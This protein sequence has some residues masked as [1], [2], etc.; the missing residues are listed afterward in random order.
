MWTISSLMINTK[1]ALIDRRKCIEQE[2]EKAENQSGES[3][4]NNNLWRNISQTSLQ[5]AEL[6]SVCL[7]C[8][9][10]CHRNG[11]PYSN[12]FCVLTDLIDGTIARKTGA[13]SK[14]GAG[15]DTAADFVFMFVCSIKILPLMHLPLWQWVWIIIIALVK[16][17][18]IALVFIC[19]KKLISIHSA[20]NK[21]TG[22]ALFLLPLTLTFAPTTYSVAAIYVLASIAVMQEV[23]FFV[24]RQEVV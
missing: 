22:F 4:I 9:F 1:S 14:F 21:T 11:L 10:L 5:A 13:V 19:K 18:N 24:K 16:I 2:Q 3:S 7:F 23:Y 6:Y 15:L 20:L 8:S 12:Y 17:L